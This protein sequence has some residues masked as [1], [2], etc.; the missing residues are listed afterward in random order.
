MAT[1]RPSV[2]GRTAG[3]KSFIRR[4][5]TEI[6]AEWRVA[7]RHIPAARQLSAVIVVDHMPELLDQ[8]GDLADVL[9][10]ERPTQE[11]FETA[12]RH[13]IDR[14]EAGFDVAAVVEEVSLLRA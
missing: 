3:V 10:R 7:A 14:L 2:T 9:A 6:L 5:R 8:I 11:T 4:F 1:D 13:A 12:R